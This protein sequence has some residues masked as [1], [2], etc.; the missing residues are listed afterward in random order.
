[1]PTAPEILSL[2]VR[3]EL[4]RG[5]EVLSGAVSVIPVTRTNGVH[6]IQRH[7]R[8]IAYAKQSGLASRL[9]GDDVVAA[10]RFA[11]DRLQ[12]LGLTP[13]LILQGGPAVVWTGAAPGR[14]LMSVALDASSAIRLTDA[15]GHALA[16][17][18]TAPVD[19]EVPVARAPW[20]LLPELLPS[21]TTHPPD[22][23]RDAVLA[24]W[25]NPD[26][27][28]ALRPLA[29]AWADG[30]HWTHGDL[31]PSNVIINVDGHV[32][33]IDWESAGRGAACWDLVTVEQTLASIGLSPN[34][35]RRAYAAVGGPGLPY[36]VAWRT[37]RALVTAWQH[38]ASPGAD[39][40]S[41]VEQLLD[42]ARRCASNAATPNQEESR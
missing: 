3:A 42:E 18:H 19:G 14:E 39:N 15:L 41:I 9:D 7:G 27:R 1:M 8:V 6:G 31:S 22:R 35:F 34:G 26:V 37:V 16:A 11:L 29:V 38:A 4:V 40:H 36:P 25:R 10:E 21:M 2:A 28:A 32:T 5:S 30:D 33:F 20:P 12:S 24:T 13:S 23:D 17:L